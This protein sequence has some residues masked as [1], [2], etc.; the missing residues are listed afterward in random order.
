MRSRLT[1]AFVLLTFLLISVFGGLRALA[2]RDLLRAQESSHLQ[3][4]AR[5]LAA[6]LD[7]LNPNGLPLQRN[8]VMGLL[9]SVAEATITIGESQ[10]V[11]VKGLEFTADEGAEGSAALVAHAS[12]GQF[13]VQLRQSSLGVQEAVGSA[14]RS[15]VALGLLLMI[16]AGVIGYLAA[17]IFV[18]PFQQLTRAAAALGRGRFDL[19]LPDSRLTEVRELAASLRGSASQL[20]RGLRREQE[21]LQQASHDVRTPLTGLRLELEELQLYGSLPEEASEGVERGLRQLSRVEEQ[22]TRVFEAAR[23][24]GTFADSQ[25][26]LDRLARDTA[27]NWSK[28]LGQRGLDLKASVDGDVDLQVLPGPVEQVLD[29]VRD[30]LLRYGRETVRLE[31]TGSGGQLQVHVR[32]GK[33]DGRVRF[34]R[35]RL[36]E[37]RTTV[38]S[39]GGRSTGDP[40]AGGLRIWLPCR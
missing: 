27:A 11:T 32:A 15:L 38:A 14:V 20:E 13:T 6:T 39:L 2:L 21:L 33:P 10:P 28:A 31:L 24:R 35:S 18:A 22:T 8:M 5:E 23:T 4:D 37:V 34:A 29:L 19:D 9:P 7:A 16:F 25:I 1:A 40:V 30:D 26:S 3:Q 17:R 12:A 36:H